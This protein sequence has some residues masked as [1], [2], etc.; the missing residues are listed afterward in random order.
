MDINKVLRQ[1]FLQYGYAK[2]YFSITRDQYDV[3]VKDTRFKYDKTPEEYLS[4][5]G[6]NI[7]ITVI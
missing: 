7:E 4:D 2:G 3:L 1:C 6:L 5:W